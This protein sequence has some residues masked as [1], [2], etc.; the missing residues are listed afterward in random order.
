MIAMIRQPRRR[1]TCIFQIA[2]QAAWSRQHCLTPPPHQGGFR[3]LAQSMRQKSQSKKRADCR[4]KCAAAPVCTAWLRRGAPAWDTVPLP[5]IPPFTRYERQNF[6]PSRRYCTSTRPFTLDLAGAGPSQRRVRIGANGIVG[7]ARPTSQQ[8]QNKEESHGI[9]QDTTLRG[10]RRD[11]HVAL[12]HE[13][14]QLSRRSGCLWRRSGRFRPRR[15]PAKQRR[16]S[17]RYGYGSHPRRKDAF[18]RSGAARLR[19]GGDRR[20][21]IR[22]LCSFRLQP[23]RAPRPSS[24]RKPTSLAASRTTPRSSWAPAL[25]SNR[26]PD[27]TSLPTRCMPHTANTTRAPAIFPWC[28]PSSTTLPIPSTGSWATGS[29]SSP[30]PKACRSSRT[31][32]ATKR[33]AAT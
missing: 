5:I 15:L 6:P 13:P 17:S 28:A 31:C 8:A 18:Q 33:C 26:T 24:W 23:R 25:R 16:R 7:R 1:R 27:T 3:P 4:T 30:A 21:H 12:R 14:T 29:G 19:R 22:H 20:W 2:I 9:E 11:C 32:P 10:G